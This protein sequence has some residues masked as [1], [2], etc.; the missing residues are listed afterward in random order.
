MYYYGEQFKQT[1][2]DVRKER[3]RT[4][5]MMKKCSVGVV[6]GL[7]SLVFLCCTAQAYYNEYTIDS[8]ING[9]QH[10]DDSAFAQLT[11]PT[12]SETFTTTAHPTP[13]AGAAAAEAYA[14]GKTSGWEYT[15]AGN[16]WTNPGTIGY[17]VSGLASGTYKISAVS[18]GFTYDSWN[19][20]SDYNQYL[21]FL[22]I[23]KGTGWVGTIGDDTKTS[24]GGVS[25]LSTFYSTW[26]TT[27]TLL[28]GETLSFYVW[29]TNTM[30]N[31]GTLRFSV[32]SVPLPSSL[33][34][35][36]SGLP[37][38]ALFRVRRFFSKK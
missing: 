36:L 33:L 9:G 10:Y 12:Y 30:D 23:V 25:G 15:S 4:M 5:L 8:V 14:N 24:T 3:R 31:M 32:A 18:G 6:F 1:A 35:A 19:W 29:D 7:I 38:M 34:L 11:S 2:A 21:Y 20:S 28:P 16:M 22:Q 37:A 27:V 17:T 13:F 26:F